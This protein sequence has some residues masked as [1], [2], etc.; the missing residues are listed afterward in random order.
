M[1]LASKHFKD[2]DRLQQC[3]VSDPHH[4]VPGE[5][6]EHVGLIQQAL[7]KL[8]EAVI[9]APEISA[10]F[11]GSTT[12]R[13]V[14]AYKTKR[15][16]INKKYQQTPDNIVGKMTIE[17][18][19]S[20]MGKLEE[21]PASLLVS[22]TEAGA[23]HDHRLCPPLQSGIHKGTPI[24]PLGFLRKI[25]IYGT[26]ETDYLRFEDYAVNPDFT[27]RGAGSSPRPITFTGPGRLKEG[28]ASDIC[29]RSSPLFEKRNAKSDPNE[30][31]EIKRI[32]MPGCRFTFGGTEEN[33]RSF[34]PTVLKL[35]PLMEKVEIKEK[36]KVGPDKF[37]DTVFT[38]F[39]LTLL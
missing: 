37:V 22:V 28:S 36:L 18:L 15:K 38:V 19:D 1:P 32:A 13:S 12:T 39:V 34:G 8:G 35:G 20:E 2:N 26:H 27:S 14:L 4:V 29:M 21:V 25:N 5:R 16:I 33:I 23:P 11:Y 30:F 9:S 17:R 6:G 24:N 31:D 3:L 7:I 10:N